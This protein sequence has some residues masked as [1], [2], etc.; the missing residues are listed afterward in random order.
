MKASFDLDRYLRQQGI[1]TRPMDFPWQKMD[2]NER[3]LTKDEAIRLINEW[4]EE[5]IPTK[6]LY[7]ARIKCSLVQFSSGVRNAYLNTML[8]YLIERIK[9]SDHDP[10]TVVATYNYEMDDVL[11]MSDA[12]HRVTHRFAGFM[13]RSSYDL[14]LYLKD[15]EK[16]LN[17]K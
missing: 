15:K 14:L 13:E 3:W 2:D 17:E 4:R 8:D 16:E 11:A 1:S 7:Y 12:D 6:N 9:K 10:I 5:A